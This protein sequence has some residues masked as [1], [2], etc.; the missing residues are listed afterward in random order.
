MQLYVT[1]TSPYARLAR[2][3]VI[4]KSLQET[5]NVIGV[6]TR[7]QDSPYYRV[8]PSGRVPYLVTE[9]GMGLEDSQVIC[10]YLDSL[11]GRPQLHDPSWISD[12]NYR[13]LEASARSLCDSISVWVREMS[14]PEHERSPTVLAHEV[15]RCQRMAEMFEKWMTDPLLHAEPGMAHLILAVSLETAARRGPC[16]LTGARPRL[17]KWLRPIAER[18]SM[19]AT[20]LPR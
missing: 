20:A 4:E 9:S 5:V 14:R 19:L 18:S 7:T 15:A 1:F 16:D 13:R 11:D 12:W 17:S 6:Q 10:A 3:V 2:I 8:N